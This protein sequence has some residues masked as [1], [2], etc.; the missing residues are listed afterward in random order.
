MTDAE[1]LAHASPALRIAGKSGHWRPAP[2]NP[3]AVLIPWRDVYRLVDAGA[4]QWGN[5]CRSFVVRAGNGC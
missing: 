1:L 2:G 5:R 4:L 3:G